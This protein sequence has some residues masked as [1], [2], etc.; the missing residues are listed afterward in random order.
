MKRISDSEILQVVNALQEHGSERKAAAALGMPR[1]TFKRRLAMA[2]PVKAETKDQSR[3]KSLESLVEKQAEVISRLRMPKIVS[4]KPLKRKASA[5]GDFVRVII[6]DTHGC[7]VDRK[8][9]EALLGDLDTLQ[10]REVIMLGDHLDCGGFLAQ[11]HTLGHVAETAYSFHD[12]VAACNYLLDELQTAAAGAE[13]CYLEGNHERR[14]EQW[15]VTQALKNGNPKDAAY[16]ASLF[17][18]EAVL[19]LEQRGIQLIKQGQWYDGLRIPATIKRGRCYFTHGTRT[20]VHAAKQTLGDFGGNV[21]FGHTH[22]IQQ[23]QSWTVGGGDIAAWNVGFL[24]KIQP[25]WRHSAPT[26]WSHGY[27]VQFVKESGEFLHLTVPIIDGT[28]FL[29][30]LADKCR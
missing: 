26:G 16:L 17:S 3:L 23:H 29:L 11:H 6:P 22:R 19:S 28:S 1:T 15:C 10:P 25:Y 21:V 27:G 30:P 2:G 14:I 8:A 5:K 7:H 9:V 12:D 13:F 20:G 18:V 24:A 4:L